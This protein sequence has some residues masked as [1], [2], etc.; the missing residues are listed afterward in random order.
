MTLA[1]TAQ[2]A[3]SEED[4]I[5][6]ELFRGREGREAGLLVGDTLTSECV[7]VRGHEV[8]SKYTYFLCLQSKCCI[9]GVASHHPLA[10]LR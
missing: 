10:K 2:D 1:T 8:T 4:I 5:W 7:Y 9:T 3:S 6:S